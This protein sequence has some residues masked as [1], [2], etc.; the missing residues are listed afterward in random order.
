M[1]DISSSKVQVLDKTFVPYKSPEDIQSQVQRIAQQINDDYADSNP[2]II[3]VL[4][5]AFMFAA[6]LMKHLHIP[7]ELSFIKVASYEGTESTGELEEILGFDERISGRHLILVEDIVDTGLTMAQL[8]ENMKDYRPASAHVATLLHKKEATT[9][10]VP[11]RYVGFEVP[12]KFLVGYGLDYDQQGRNLEALY[13]L[14][15]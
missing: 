14:E 6:D 5:G 1:N 2:L 4:N 3:P 15:E 10:H 12:N 13:Q 8:L 9:E 7:C 11:L